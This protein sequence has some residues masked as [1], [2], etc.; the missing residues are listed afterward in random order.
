MVSD[1]S[2]TTYEERLRSVGLSSLRE[3]RERGDA[4]KT[5]KTLKG[6]NKIDGRNWFEISGPDARA[7]RRTTSVSEEGETR[8]EGS[9][10]RQNFKLEVR[11]NFFTVRVVA[12]WNALPDWVREQQTINSFKNAY[13]RWKRGSDEAK[14]I[15]T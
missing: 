7:T 6:F 12:I 3:R 5:F 2:G 13:D 9:L 14:T 15:Q 1:K 4:I 11:K 10:Y 8:R